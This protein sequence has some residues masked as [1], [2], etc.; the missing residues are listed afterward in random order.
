MSGDPAAEGFSTARFE[1]VHDLMLGATRS[2][3]YLGAV[4]LIARN[5]KIVDWRAYGYLDLGKT[6]AMPRDA[7]FRIYS[8]TKTV[9]TVAALVLVEDGKIAL[10]DRLGKHLP[11]FSNRPVTIR[12]LLTHTSGFSAPSEAMEK[13]ADLKAYS[14][15]AAALAQ[16]AAPGS[17]FEYNSVNTEVASRIIEVASGKSF[18]T[19]LR[20]RI[21]LPLA[22]RDTGFTV[23]LEQRQRIAAM[24][25]TDPD[26]R[27]VSQPAGD[28]KRPGEPMRSYS[29]G[30]GGLYSTAGDFARF[31]QMLVD[32]GRLDD[33]TILGRDSVATMMTN[34]LAT[35]DPPVSQYDEGFGLGGFV[36][37]DSP[38]RKRPG[39]VGAFGWS[40]AA[41]TYS[42]DDPRERMFA[43]LL[44]QHLPRGLSRDPQKISFTFYNLVYQSLMK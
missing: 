10:D 27:L 32:G 33:V 31:C 29:S 26:G 37:L 2:G 44:M 15:G 40:G 3:D 17:R 13:S 38:G 43:I 22:M 25:S 34:Q 1:R 36:N 21:F 16:A 39:S 35:L 11:E 18:E 30:A 9:A 6:V 41:A 20:E 12:Q 19:F 7:I 14:E 8:M 23:P 5:G 4:T 24:T 42:M 28:A